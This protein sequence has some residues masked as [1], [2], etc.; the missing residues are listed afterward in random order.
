MSENTK[1]PG[2]FD[3]AAMAA[4][5]THINEGF[6]HEALRPHPVIEGY[7]VANDRQLAESYQVAAERMP[8]PSEGKQGVVLLVGNGAFEMAAQMLPPEHAFVICANGATTLGIQRVILETIRNC[9]T[10][11]EFQEAIHGF[12]EEFA[13][14]QLAADPSA[15]PLSPV[16]SRYEGQQVKWNDSVI[17]YFLTSE[18]AYTA[19]RDALADRPIAFRQID[20]REVDEV[21]ALAADLTAQNAEVVGANVTNV[22]G[23]GWA[24]PDAGNE[25]VQRLPF[26][27]DAPILDSVGGTMNSE[28]Y[29]QEDWVARNE[30]LISD[31]ALLQIP[32]RYRPWPGQ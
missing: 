24:Q 25:L 1:Q 17:P 8:D 20:L 30:Q 29:T 4:S 19:A 10:V 18:D 21:D 5:L 11:E 12:D 9:P 23:L 28:V 7:P 6:M 31:A 32:L 2:G 22:Y 3:P 16:S 13:R 15:T 26:H 14:L 27:A